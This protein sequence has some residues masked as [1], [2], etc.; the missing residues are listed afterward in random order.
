MHVTVA[1]FIIIYWFSDFLPLG[2]SIEHSLRCLPSELNTSREIMTSVTFYVLLNVSWYL[3]IC[4][5]IYIYKDIIYTHTH[6]HMKKQLVNLMEHFSI[7]TYLFFGCRHL[8]TDHW[9]EVCPSQD[10]QQCL[11]FFFFLHSWFL[12]VSLL[13]SLVCLNTVCYE[14]A[15]EQSAS[16]V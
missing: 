2:G 12:G 16:G 15:L 13:C 10:L 4:V 14:S 8:K 6:T 9:L 11:F 3:H 7:F 1:C 5:H